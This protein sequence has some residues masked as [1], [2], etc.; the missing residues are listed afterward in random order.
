MLEVGSGAGHLALR[1]AERAD[2]VDAVDIDPLM[3][4]A[5][6]AIVPANVLCRRADVMADDM[7][8][9][10]YDA[11]VSL[12]V[13]H[14]LDL[15]PALT[16]FADALRP[17]GVLVA[18]ALPRVDLPRELLVELSAAFV[19]N[20]IGLILVMTRHPLRTGLPHPAHPGSVPLKDP[21]LTTRQ[22]RAAA[23]EVLPSAKVRRLLLWRYSLTWQK[24]TDSSATSRLERIQ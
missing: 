7:P 16:R 24:S 13:L 12:S 15:Q 9:G 23:S 19:H 3:V 4:K 14:H 21:V 6:Q 11:I 10:S 1:L 2:H 5:T 20:A 8:P 17:G 22:V 18:V